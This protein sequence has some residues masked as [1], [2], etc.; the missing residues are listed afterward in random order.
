MNGELNNASSPEDE[1]IT[2]KTQKLTRFED[3]GVGTPM[4]HAI[5]RESTITS[6][7]DEMISRSR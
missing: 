4:L 2:I 5:T 6:K 3:D 7:L 1:Y